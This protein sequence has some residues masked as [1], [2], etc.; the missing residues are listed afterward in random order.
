[1]EK[2]NKKSRDSVAQQSSARI[3]L[4]LENDETLFTSFIGKTN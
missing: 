4:I 1:M 2:Q 3:M